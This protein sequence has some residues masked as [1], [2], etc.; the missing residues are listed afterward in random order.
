MSLG[1]AEVIDV[2]F[3]IANIHHDIATAEGLGQGTHM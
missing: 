2:Y 3:N 1:G